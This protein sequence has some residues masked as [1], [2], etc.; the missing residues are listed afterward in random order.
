[1]EE[2]AMR[3]IVL[4]AAACVVL[5]SAHVSARADGAWCA[6]DSLGCTNCGFQSYAQCRAYLAGIGGS[7][8][9]NT[10]QVASADARARKPRSN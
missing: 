2:T 9:R 7:C 4:A 5:A 8:D 1:M 3:T 6:R 10:A